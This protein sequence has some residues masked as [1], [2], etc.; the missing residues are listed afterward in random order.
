M[1][2]TKYFLDAHWEKVTTKCKP[3]QFEKFYDFVSNVEEASSDAKEF[4]EVFGFEGFGKFGL[5]SYG[6]KGDASL[7]PVIQV[8]DPMDRFEMVKNYIFE[9]IDG[10]L[11]KAF[12]RQYYWDFELFGYGVEG[13][14]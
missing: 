8:Q 5:A 11:V 7:E 4:Q 10:S 12:Y 2:H 3:C 6:R 1:A 9:E 13:F 14:V